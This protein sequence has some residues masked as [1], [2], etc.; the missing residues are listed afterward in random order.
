MVRLLFCFL[1]QNRRSFQLLGIVL[2]VEVDRAVERQR[3]KDR[4][5]G[6]IRVVLVQMLHRLL[7][8]P[9]PH[10]MVDLVVVLVEDLDCGEV[11]GFARRLRLRGFAFLYRLRAGLEVGIREGRYEPIAQSGSSLM[12]AWK[13][14]IV[15]G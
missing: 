1:I 15:S 10:I 5:F 11:F 13:A 2:V 4:R 6:I 9:S 7:V 12:M 14:L 8:E 3:V